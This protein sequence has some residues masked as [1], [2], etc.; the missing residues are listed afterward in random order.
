MRYPPSHNVA[1]S[2]IAVSLELPCDASGATSQRTISRASRLQQAARV[3]TKGSYFMIRPSARLPLLVTLFSILVMLLHG[4][5]HQLPHY[6]DFADSR[7]LPGLPNAADV[8]SNAGFLIVG[9]WGM[10][11]LWP[12]RHHPALASGW[13]GYRLFLI[14]LMLTAIGSGYYHL[15]PDNAR[16]LW[17]RLP[18]ALAC[19]ALLGGVH[20]ETAIDGEKRLNMVLLGVAAV[21][22]VA[23]WYRGGENGDLRPYLLL[24]SLPVVLIPLWQ[25]IR[26]A[27]AAD[28]YAFGGA[29]LLYAVAKIAE[30]NDHQ[31]LSALGSISGHTI[32]HL[33][34][35]A[36]AA[37]II[38]RLV[39]RT[40]NSEGAGFRP[41]SSDCV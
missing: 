39:R 23:W 11:R 24:Q 34:A 6:H 1:S 29:I 9:C 28:R 3:I 32:K 40:R 21:L 41:S 19:A 16:L 38:A 37:V 30:L 5:I 18:I 2:G 12:V 8:L 20:N 7:S 17:D 14:A 15:A 33:L 36:A 25:W 13:S 10:L 27:P 26:Q 4:P 35:T 31:L 22:T